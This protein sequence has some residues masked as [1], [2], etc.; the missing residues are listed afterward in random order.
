VSLSTFLMGDEA[1][2]CGSFRL[3]SCEAVERGVVRWKVHD[4]ARVDGACMFAWIVS[5][6]V[7]RIH[8]QGR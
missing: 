2:H 7:D 1:G 8:L 3:V 6:P 5:R 4:I